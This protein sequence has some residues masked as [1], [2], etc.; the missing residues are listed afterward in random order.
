MTYQRNEVK[1]DYE[2]CS[3]TLLEVEEK[4]QETQK[5]CMRLLKQCKIKDDELGHLNLMMEEL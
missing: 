4:R 1:I 2:Q 5:M 3:N